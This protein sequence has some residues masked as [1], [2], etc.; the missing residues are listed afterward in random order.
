VTDNREFNAS[1][2]DDS[3]ATTESNLQLALARVVMR[4][5]VRSACVYRFADDSCTLV[6]AQGVRPPMSMPLSDW[7]FEEDRVHGN[8]ESLIALRHLAMSSWEVLRVGSRAVGVVGLGQPV[9]NERVHDGESRIDTELQNLALLLHCDSLERKVLDSVASQERLGLLVQD[10]VS[11]SRDLVAMRSERAVIATMTYRIMGRLMISEIALILASADGT[12]SVLERRQP[13]QQLSELYFLASAL[14]GAMGVTEIANVEMQSTFAEHGISLVVPLRVHGVYKGCLVCG[15]RLDG[16]VLTP[17]GVAFAEAVAV[18]TLAVLENIRLVREEV[19]KQLLET[20]VQIATDIQRN[21]L[22][23]QLPITPMVDVAA[24]SAAARGV[25]GDYYDVIR[26][27]DGRTLVAIADVAGKGIPA[28]ILMAN[29]Q[30]ALNILARLDLPI[31]EVVTRMNT[32]ICDNTEV[33][34]FVTMF[35]AYIDPDRGV[36]TYVNAG[37]N[38]PILMEDT[39]AVDLIVGGPLLGVIPNPPPYKVGEHSFRHGDVLVLYTDGVSEIGA[40]RNDEFGVERLVNCVNERR[41]Q[42]ATDILTSVLDRL[43]EHAHPHSPDDDYSLIIVKH[44]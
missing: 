17:D 15:D 20:E 29:V 43:H 27:T 3:F 9:M 33:E 11:V 19:S 28:A 42:S 21:L 16:N 13:R 35:V 7:T 31:D 40:T 22:P 41:H 2:A 18:T 37:H 12:V 14:E 32:L 5:H 10:L 6:A 44:L 8:V 1:F 36:L 34:V 38:P 30:A 25:S 23:V 26:M 24:H 4:C 39:A